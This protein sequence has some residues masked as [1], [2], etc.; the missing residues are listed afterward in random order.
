MLCGG[1]P[2]SGEHLLG[3]TDARHVN[4]DVVCEGCNNGWMSRLQTAVKPILI[5]LIC[6]GG[7]LFRYTSPF[8]IAR[9]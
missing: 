1:G 8:L 5:P 4:L 2:M 7:A 3:K 9:A 6:P